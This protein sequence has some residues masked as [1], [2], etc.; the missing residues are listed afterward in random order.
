MPSLVPFGSEVVNLTAH[1]SEKG[2]AF[3]AL[4]R[5]LVRKLPPVSIEYPMD[6]LSIRTKDM[7]DGSFESF[8]KSISPTGFSTSPGRYRQTS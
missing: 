5:D 4:V 6:V 3:E 2:I 1:P 8:N 7:V